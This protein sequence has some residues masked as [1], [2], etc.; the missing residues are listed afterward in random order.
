MESVDIPLCTKGHLSPKVRSVQAPKDPVQT[1]DQT[2]KTLTLEMLAILPK[3]PSPA[4]EAQNNTPASLLRRPSSSPVLCPCSPLRLCQDRGLCRT[5]DCNMLTSTD[6]EEEEEGWRRRP[7]LQ[8]L[9][10]EEASTTLSALTSN[11]TTTV[12]CLITLQ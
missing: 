9:T 5:T 12:G 7:R 3:A 1:Q 11:I 4:A 10:E 2:Q 6:Q 8:P